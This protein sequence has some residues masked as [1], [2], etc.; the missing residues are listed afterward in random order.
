MIRKASD[1]K[2]YVR[3]VLSGVEHLYFY[4]GPCRFGRGEELEVGFDRILNSLRF[5]EF[6]ETIKGRMPENVE[7]LEPLYIKRTDDWEDKEQV[8]EDFRRSMLDA[9]VAFIFSSLGIDD[10][11]VELAERFDTPILM[12]PT[13][14]FS[15]QSIVAAV[16]AKDPDREI[17]APLHWTDAKET[18]AAMRARKVIRSTNILLATRFNSDVSRSSVDTFSNHDLVT[19]NLGVHFRYINAHELLDDMELAKP[20]GNHTTPGRKTWNITEEELAEC[21]RM[22]DELI[23]GADEVEI[24]REYLINS[25]KAFVAVQKRMDEKDCNG[26]TIPCP[27]VCS[28]R[29]LN[30]MK[31][32]FC[33]TH[34]LNM[35]A[36]I[37]SSCEYDADCVLSQQA[38]LAV[39]GR[40]TYIGNTG[41]IPYDRENGEYVYIW[42][43][44]PEKVAE[45]VK[46]NLENIFYMQH[47]VPH[48][49]LR[50]PNK[51]N[52]YAIRHFAWQQEFGA[53]FRYDFE[54]D[55]GQTVTMCRFSPDGSKLFV[56]KGEI[57]GGDGYKLQNCNGLVLFRVKD[58][59]DFWNKQ[60]LVGNHLALVYGDYTKQLSRLAKLLGI[61]ELVAY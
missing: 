30:E 40:R 15:P 51:R 58:Q 39:S 47:S 46:E 35:E 5:N 42:G 10:I 4:E 11:T 33:L 44:S 28:T 56:G 8:F 22:A 32:T 52:N 50:D 38:M 25:L 60:V 37:P 45:L 54:Q 17:I 31:F 14:A 19:K 1:I 53:V 9:D 48:R 18:L 24:S 12:N 16:K 36:G 6:I 3:P 29:R 61:E 55:K 20:E 34:S 27:D 13:S 26:F 23:A 7:L 59:E 41:P 57:I 2:L 43:P 21:E 49:L